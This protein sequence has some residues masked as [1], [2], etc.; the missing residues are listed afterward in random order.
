MPAKQS[1]KSAALTAE[2]RRTLPETV[3][4]PA[5]VAGPSGSHP[6]IAAVARPVTVPV[7]APGGP[8]QAHQFPD[9]LR[10]IPENQNVVWRTCLWCAKHTSAVDPDKAF[11]RCQW[12]GPERSCGNCSSKKQKCD[13]EVCCRT[14]VGPL[15]MTADPRP[16]CSGAGAAAADSAGVWCKPNS[17]VPL[18]R[19]AAEVPPHG[20]LRPIPGPAKAVERVGQLLYAD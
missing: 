14:C 2:R 19:R 6:P 12:A 15:L 8:R 11:V 16:I 5:S 7:V 18:Q 13:R 3:L 10:G 20:A 4:D 9:V 1:K 17:A